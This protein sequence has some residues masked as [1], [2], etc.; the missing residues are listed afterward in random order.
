MCLSYIHLTLLQVIREGS[1]VCVSWD[2][3]AAGNRGNWST[4]GCTRV[5]SSDGVVTCQCTHLTNFA[6]LIVSSIQIITHAM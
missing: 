5:A 1:E 3:M 6:V 4:E 2:F